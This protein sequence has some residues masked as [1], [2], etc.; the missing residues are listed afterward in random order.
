MQGQ[1]ARLQQ[2]QGWAAR[3]FY[4]SPSHAHIGDQH[5]V[6]K[7]PVSLAPAWS[8]SRLPRLPEGTVPGSR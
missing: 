8:I 3:Q 6:S 4:A 2:N 7:S 5:K 1:S